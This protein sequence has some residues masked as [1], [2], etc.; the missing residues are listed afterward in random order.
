MVFYYSYTSLL[1]TL[2]GKG[3]SGNCKMIQ[4]YKFKSCW[5]KEINIVVSILA[6]KK[7][8]STHTNTPPAGK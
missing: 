6:H 7:N 1:R 2:S 4:D 5:F 3:N 8:P